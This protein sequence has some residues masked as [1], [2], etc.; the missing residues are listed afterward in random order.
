MYATQ[1]AA[2]FWSPDTPSS[3]AP[4]SSFYAL[5]LFDTK[6]DMEKTGSPKT[7]TYVMFIVSRVIQFACSYGQLN[8][9][10][11]MLGYLIYATH[12]NVYLWQ[13]F[14]ANWPGTVQHMCQCKARQNYSTIPEH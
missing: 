7:N 14:R 6:S 2:F 10:L 5:L 3:D 12:A 13:I 9:M 4:E 11:F 1:G 8:N